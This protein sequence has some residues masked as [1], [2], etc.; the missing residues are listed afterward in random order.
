MT[1]WPTG[2]RPHV[3]IVGQAALCKSSPGRWPDVMFPTASRAF[4]F[5]C[6]VDPLLKKAEPSGPMNP[7]CEKRGEV[8][9]ASQHCQMVERHDLVAGL[10]RFAR[11]ILAPSGPLVKGGGGDNGMAALPT[12]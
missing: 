12:D 2:L 1:H 11:C 7:I 6:H 10:S 9:R 8:T 3:S 5:W 4:A